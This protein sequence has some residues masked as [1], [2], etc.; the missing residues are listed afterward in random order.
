M[1]T[2]GA[3]SRSGAKWLLSAEPH[4]ILRAKRVFAQT[5]RQHKGVLT[6]SDTVDTCRDLAWFLERYP[7][8]MDEHDRAHLEARSSAHRERE[9]LVAQLLAGVAQPQSFPLAIEPRTYQRI[10]ADIAL[11]TRGLLL[12]D[13][14][15]LGKSC[16]AICVLSDP[17]TRPALVVTL[18]HL[19]R[20]WVSEFQKF[21]PGLSVHV[22]KK[23]SPYDLTQGPRAKKGQLSMPGTFP[24]VIVTS[25]SK[26]AGWA[27][28]LAPLVK[29]V[30]YDEC[31][32]ADTLVRLWPHGERRIDEL[33]VG[34]RIASFD[35]D[36]YIV[37]GRVVAIVPKGERGVWR[38]T[39]TDGRSI[40]CTDNERIWT[41]QGWIY[42]REIIDA[43]S[44]EN[45]RVPPQADSRDGAPNDSRHLAWRRLLGAPVGRAICATQYE[46]QL[47]TGGLLSTQSGAPLRLCQDATAYHHESGLRARKLRLQH[48]DLA[49]VRVFGVSVLH[50][51][52]GWATSE[53]RLTGVGHGVGLASNCLLVHGRRYD[54]EPGRGGFFDTQLYGAGGPAFGATTG[55][56]GGASDRGSGAEARENLLDAQAAFGADTEA[57]GADRAVRARVDGL[58]ARSSGAPAGPDL[59][60]MRGGGPWCEAAACSVRRVQETGVCAV[61]PKGR[62]CVRLSAAEIA[63]VERAGSAA[64]WDIETEIHHTFFANGIAVHNCQELRTGNSSNK[65]SAAYAISDSVELRL[66]LSGTPIYNYGSEIWNVVRALNREALGTRTEFLTEW[67]DGMDARGRARLKNPKAFGTYMLDTGLMLRRTREEV[68]REL[69]EVVRVPHVVSCDEAPLRGVEDAAASLAS[70]VLEKVETERGEKMHA[71]EELSALV[72]HATGVAKGPYVAEFVKFIL[73]S[74]EPVVL[75]GWHRDCY[76]IWTDRLRAYNP[77]LYTGTESPAQKDEAK[78]KFL[79]GETNLLIMSLRSGLGLDGLQERC[80]NVVF[81]EL[82]WSPGVMEQCLTRVHRDGQRESVVVYYLIADEGS[83][84]IV[85]D[86]LNIKR[87]Q[88]EGVRNPQ[89]DLIEKLDTSGDRVRRLAETYLRRVA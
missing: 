25:Y 50:P 74:G 51:C 38:I 42:A 9:S 44:V 22:L 24:D 67:C 36:G 7:V 59:H 15:G 1:K 37:E 84:P 34:D 20:Q 71:A 43:A 52:S 12:A 66:A 29:S 88:V 54:A 45:S 81:G 87:A 53:D 31:L 40:V 21:T 23:G 26:L 2:Y 28:T 17:A 33:I 64:V 56:L 79:S 60:G 39:L 86:V 77:V 78:R 83:D 16:S 85:A 72:R 5:S 69:P 4:V 47:E 10:A 61:A 80:R 19:T 6:L 41:D 32:A 62:L 46:S 75:F 58:Q 13:D 27:E 35:A 65:G 89:L 82:D 70:V 48:R 18:T 76:A 49:R 11:K 30:V 55:S 8:T 68:G 3:L 57:R 63:R 14:M 73:E